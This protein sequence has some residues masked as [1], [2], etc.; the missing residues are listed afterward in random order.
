LLLPFARL[1]FG[2]GNIKP[3]IQ[4]AYGPGW[5]KWGSESK[6]TE[7]LNPFEADGSIAFFVNRNIAID[8]A[9][10]YGSAIYKYTDAFKAEW[11]TTANGIGGNVGFTICF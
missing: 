3:Y 2:K 10:G 7:N 11:K 8:L 9:I 1:Y 6:Q 4:A 5:Q